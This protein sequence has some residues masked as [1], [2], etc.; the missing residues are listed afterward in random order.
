MLLSVRA[1]GV[2]LNLQAASTVIMYDSGRAR[3]QPAPD[4]LRRTHSCSVL[5]LPVC[6]M[7]VMHHGCTRVVRA[8]ATPVVACRWAWAYMHRV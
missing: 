6:M 2:G 7:A 8:V 5:V 4:M 1:G 3:L